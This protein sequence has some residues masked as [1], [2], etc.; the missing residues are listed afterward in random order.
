MLHEALLTLT[1]FV[2]VIH[3]GVTLESGVLTRNQESSLDFMSFSALCFSE[4]SGLFVNKLTFPV[5]L[6]QQTGAVLPPGDSWQRPDCQV[7]SRCDGRRPG[8][9]LN[10]PLPLRHRMI[11]LQAS[12]VPTWRGPTLGHISSLSVKEKK[13]QEL[14]ADLIISLP[15]P[16]VVPKCC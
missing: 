2:S 10:T 4:A 5:D 14:R 13:L 1:D 7:V 12:M 8:I 6:G 11:R 3:S 15:L 16:S 9:P